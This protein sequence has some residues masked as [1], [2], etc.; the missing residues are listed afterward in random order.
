LTLT[1]HEPLAGMV[2]PVG[3]PNVKIV[4]PTAGAHVGV[5][6]HVVVAEGVAAT[7][8]PVGRVSVNVAPVNAVVFE[9]D[10]VNVNVET[11][12]TA[13]GL[14]EKTFVMVAGT[15]RGQP[16]NRTLSK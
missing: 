1:V 6:P 15:G 3:D 9:L 12:L 14:G 16:M 11:P 10:K 13:I 8:R 2:P 5:P 4:A 7:C